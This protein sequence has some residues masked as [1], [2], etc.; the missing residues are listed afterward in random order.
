MCVRLSNVRTSF[1]SVPA[2]SSPANLQ[3]SR[4]NPADGG[5]YLCSVSFQSGE[6]RTHNV[7]LRVGSTYRS[8]R[9][10]YPGNKLAFDVCPSVAIQQYRLDRDDGPPAVL[11]FR[12]VIRQRRIH[13]SGAPRTQ[14]AV[15]GSETV[16]ESVRDCPIRQRLWYWAGGRDVI[17]AMTRTGHHEG[18]RKSVGGP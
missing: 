13:N 5:V 10:S 14:Q 8:R 1:R 12:I 16:R 7:S 2:L 15:A 6:V 3:L 18:D 17:Q 4:L 9:R 11:K